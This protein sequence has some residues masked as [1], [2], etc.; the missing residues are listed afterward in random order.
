M[1]EERKTRAL[2]EHIERRVV[3]YVRVGRERWTQR[4][5]RYFADQD[6]MVALLERAAKGQG[7]VAPTGPWR[8]GVTVTLAPAKS[9]GKMPKT[10]GDLDNVVKAISDAAQ[11][12]GIVPD[13]CHLVSIVAGKQLGERDSVKFTIWYYEDEQP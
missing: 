4:A 11:K 5:K 12:A 8:L 1:T 7:F 3:P 2:Y 10:A 6:R 9:T 13:D